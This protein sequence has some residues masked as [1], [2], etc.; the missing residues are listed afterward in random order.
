MTGR[1]KPLVHIQRAQ[2]VKF[3]R[4]PTPKEFQI[5]LPPVACF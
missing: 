5:G 4:A 1:Q 2:L 3:E